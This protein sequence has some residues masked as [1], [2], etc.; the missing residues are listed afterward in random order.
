MSRHATAAERRYMGRVAELG[1]IVCR[2]AGFGAT[3][4]EVHHVREG[5]GGAQRAPNY[6]VIPLCPEHHRGKDSIHGARRA[7]E[8][9]YGSELDL[10]AQTIGELAEAT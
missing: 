10:L 8:L 2:N 6:L 4:A 9:R 1:C 3:P 7:F 5:Q